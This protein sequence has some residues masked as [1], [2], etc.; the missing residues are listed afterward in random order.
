M[1]AR[2]L[3]CRH[4]VRMLAAVAS[5]PRLPD[6]NDNRT[7]PSSRRV[8]NDFRLCMYRPM[9]K[10]WRSLSSTS[11]R[12]CSSLQPFFEGLS[13]AWSSLSLNSSGNCGLRVHSPDWPGATTVTLANALH[14]ERYAR[15][16]PISSNLTVP[17]G[18]KTSV[19]RV[20]RSNS[21]RRYHL[22]SGESSALNMNG[23]KP[24]GNVAFCPVPSPCNDSPSS[25]QR[26][27]DQRS[28]SNLSRI[29]PA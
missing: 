18:V 2:Y 1:S 16:T 10:P 28:W 4:H 19:G 17:P 5:S 27:R 14:R 23:K 9:R 20:P 25:V 21:R 6:R 7:L 15:I 22:V 13:L 8:M 29:A 12:P 26:G 3:P 11:T 24:R